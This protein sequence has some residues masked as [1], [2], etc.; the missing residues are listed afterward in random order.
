M[1]EELEKK[2]NKKNESQMGFEP[3]TLRDLVPDV[4]SDSE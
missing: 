2:T 3:R 4:S 1:Q